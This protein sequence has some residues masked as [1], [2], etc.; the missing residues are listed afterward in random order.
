MFGFRPERKSL[1]GLGARA[2][3]LLWLVAGIAPAAAQTPAVSDYRLR[4]GDQI[5]LAVLQ[6]PDLDRPLTVRADGVI[7]VP[8]VGEVLVADLT[9]REAAELVRQRLRLFNRDIAD[10][11]LTLTQYY[12]LRISVLGA[13]RQP[14]EYTFPAAPS[15]WD[16]LRAA[17]GPAPGANLTAVRIVRQEGSDTRTEF[18]DFSMILDGEQTVPP[19]L[20]RTGD[21]VVVPSGDESL[22][23]P[24]ANTIQVIG[25]VTRQGS[26][27][28][29]APARLVSVLVMA[30]GPLE[31]GDLRKVWWVHDEGGGRYR[32]T[33]VNVHDFLRDGKLVG[34]PIVYPGDTIRVPFRGGGFFGSVWP[35]LL[36]SVT[37]ATAILIASS[38]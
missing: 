17:G 10:V 5:Q 11:S 24:T 13:V 20:L 25:G 23:R 22:L 32:S 2:V 1:V 18:H 38:R 37:A 31:G 16:V 26:L 34:N 19:V 15:V 9:V 4:A 3:A 7:V 36:S 30:G 35:V 21:S 28:L 6:Q 12:A 8:L 14:G 27:S 33:R 29:T